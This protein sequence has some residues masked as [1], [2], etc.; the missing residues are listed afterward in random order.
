M[1]KILRYSFVALLAMVF[2]NVMADDVTDVLTW[3]KLLPSGKGTNY[4]E[5]SGKT[6]TSTAVYA[7]L[8]S[9]GGD[10]YIQLRTSDNKSGIVT[11]ASGGK[12]KSITITFNAK[13]SNRAIQIFG[14]NEAYTA[15]TDLY[16]ANTRGTSLKVIG[17]ADES[18]TLTVEGDYTF[19]GLKSSSGAV[20][21][22]KIE[23]VW[24]SAGQGGNTKTA[25]TI[26][27]SG[28]YET[29]ATCGKDESV[30]LPTATVKAGES[31]VA[32]ATVTWESSNTEIATVNGNKLNIANGTQ[33]EVTIK[34]SYAGNDTYAASTKSYKLTVYKGAMLLSSMVEDVTSSNEKWDNGGELVSYWFVN[35]NFQ[36][37]TNTVTFVKGKN[38]YLTD[39]TN[40]LLF[41]GTNTLNLKQGDVI[42]GDLGDGK[43]G[44]VWGTLYRYKKLP[45][46]SFTEMDVKVQSEGATV[47][48]KTITPDKLGENI[49]A[50]LEIKDAEF[51]SANNQNL[52]FKV[53]ETEF[54]VRQNW[55]DVA[56]DGLEANAK[57]TILGMGAVYNTTNQLYLISFTK[58]ADAS[59]I[60][61]VKAAQQNGAIYNVA[62]QMVTPSYKGLVIKN[63]RKYIQK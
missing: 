17:D 24:E 37:V 9:S 44:A 33:G 5:F 62:G 21:V 34:A 63:G 46:F 7:G 4:T 15:A 26:D 28:D 23:I 50:Y 30:S 25:T 42:S 3:D 12:L 56:I 54:I 32:G 49:N 40:N 59:G 8:M 10:S 39:G 2:G 55:T 47:T 11:T 58:T 18:K 51:V 1:N 22:D 31:A 19:V 27:F 14:K 52:T 53:D 38:I 45:E 41:Y 6:I 48:P 57:Y 29:R 43:M 35:E 16:N 36:S 61:A 20:Y 60:N 13:T